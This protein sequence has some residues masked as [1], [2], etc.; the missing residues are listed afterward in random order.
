[1]SQQHPYS[2]RDYSHLVI[3]GLLAG[4]I[5]SF[6]TS[7]MVFIRCIETVSFRLTDRAGTGQ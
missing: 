3:M 2:K 4:I 7:Q 6:A 1:M 5:F